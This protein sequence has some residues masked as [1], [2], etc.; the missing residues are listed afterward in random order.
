MK[1]AHALQTKIGRFIE[2]EALL[3]QGE[4]VVVAVSGGPDSMALLHL[5]FALSNSYGWS[6]V[7]AHADHGFRGEESAE[8]A[9][10]VMST[11]AAWGIPCFVTRLD[12]PAYLQQHGGNPQAVSRERR[13]AFLRDMAI[14]VGAT[15]IVLAHHADDQAE[16]VLMRLLRGTSLSGLGGIPVRRMYEPGIELVRPLIRVYK[17]ELLDYCE[18]VGIPYRTDSS[19]LDTK[20][21]RNRIRLEVMPFLSRYE[22]RLPE[23]LNR[24]ALVAADENDWLEAQTRE[25]CKSNITFGDGEAA[26]SAQ[27]FGGVHVALQRRLIKLILSYLKYDPERVVFERIEH[28]RSFALQG[29]AGN[30]L[31]LIEPSLTLRREYDRVILHTMVLPTGSYCYEVHEGQ[32]ELSIAKTRTRL[33]FLWLDRAEAVVGQPADD[34]AVFDLANISLPIYIRSRRDGDRMSPFGLNGSKKVKDMF[35]DA[36]VAARNRE[37]TPIIT[38]GEGRLLWLPGVRRS[39]LAPVTEETKRLLV[40][41]LYFD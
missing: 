16:T 35:I 13:Y 27:W 28:I 32:A 15:S 9:S 1:D 24:L 30:A 8:E 26:W 10:F 25:V 6:I 2:D 18:A 22:E 31:L 19:N 41:R 29:T 33:S 14:Q 11:A 4:G 34:E 38:D 5:L 21:T 20:Y 12:M 37:R 7:A 3:K 40:M 39:S 36:K 23:T 17:Q